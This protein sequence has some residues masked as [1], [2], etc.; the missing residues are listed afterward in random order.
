MAAKLSALYRITAE[1]EKER[2]TDLLLEAADYCEVLTKEMVILASHI[3][4]HGT[5]LNAVDMENHQ[6]VVILIENEQKMVVA[7]YLVQV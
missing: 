7:E 1:T 3:E 5:V 6:F 4:S 2:G